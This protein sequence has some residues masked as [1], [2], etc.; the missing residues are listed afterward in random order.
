MLGHHAPGP[1]FGEPEAPARYAEFQHRFRDE[2]GEL[3]DENLTAACL[4]YRQR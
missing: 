4:R 3:T 2:V 1:H